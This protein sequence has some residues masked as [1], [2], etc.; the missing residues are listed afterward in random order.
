MPFDSPS[1][2][3][4]PDPA[5]T[6]AAQSAANKETAIAQA[7][8]NMVNQKT[9]QGTLTFND[10]GKWSDGTPRYEA[11]TTLSPEEQNLYGINT[12]TRT[13]IANIGKDQSARIGDILGTPF[14]IEAARGE[15]IA[16]ISRTFLDPQWERARNSLEADLFNRGVKPGSEAYTRAVQDFET[17]RTNAY[18]KMFLDAFT[19]GNTAALTERNQPINEITALMSGSQ[20][21]QPNWVNTPNTGVQPTDVIGPTYSNYQAQVGNY[22]NAVSRNN[23]MMGGLFGLASAPLGGWATRGFKF[24]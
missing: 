4:P 22:N 11:V 18:N 7:G 12:A 9:P 19:T 21:S 15:K 2:P 10:I 6:A 17:N 5:A 24:G 14:N 1:P 23:A 20:V 13:N 8:L 16:D 3:P